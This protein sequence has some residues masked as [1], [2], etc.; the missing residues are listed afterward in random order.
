ML[1]DFHQFNV[2]VQFLACHFMVGIKGDGSVI[3]GGHFDRNGLTG[4]GGQN[5]VLAD[6]QILAAG[7]LADF[8]REVMLS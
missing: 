1:L 7:H 6:L 2:E 8:Y 4:A 5:N 3:T